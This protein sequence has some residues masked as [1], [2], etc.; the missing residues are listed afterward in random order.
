MTLA[1]KTVID[2][3][4][5]DLAIFLHDVISSK[6]ASQASAEDDN[7]MQ[8]DSVSAQNSA[9]S[10]T[11]LL[12][13][14]VMYPTS[15]AAMRVAI[16]EH[17]READELVVILKELTRWVEAWFNEEPK[18]LPEQAKKGDYGVLVPVIEVSKRED[19]PP[20]E[21]VR[22]FQRFTSH[23]LTH[24]AQLP[25]ARFSIS[26]KSSSTP[27]SLPSS[28]IHPHTRS[29]NVSCPPSNPNSLSTMKSNNSKVHSNLSSVLKRKRYQMRSTVRQRL[30]R[31]WIG[32]SGRRRCMNRR[33]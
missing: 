12:A 5:T 4:E 17:L 1:L 23:P 26:Y 2:V 22:D 33:V 31:R 32:G 3:P 18:L 15:A 29:S 13:L 25:L 24:F 6:S 20:L 30:T 11:D 9:P 7:S 8:I 16:R 28:P 27:P 14:V 19:I 10:V 21:K